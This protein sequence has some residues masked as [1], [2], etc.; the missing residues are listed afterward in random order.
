M[1]IK[2]RVST[3][4][5][6]WKALKE[7]KQEFESNKEFQDFLDQDWEW[8][9]KNAKVKKRRPRIKATP[10]KVRIKAGFIELILSYSE[11]NENGRVG[12]IVEEIY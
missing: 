7:A 5:E 6:R 4:P 8:R 2:Q 3:S 12:I 1:K 11:W 9:L 10:K